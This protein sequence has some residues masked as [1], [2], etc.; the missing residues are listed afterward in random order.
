VLVAGGEQ[1]VVVR[2]YDDPADLEKPRGKQDWQLE[3]HIV[4]YPRTTGIWQTVWLEVVP[5]THLGSLR[6]RP[7]VPAWSI[8]VEACVGGA[9]RENLRL[10]VELRLGDEVLVD[11]AWAV[12]DGEV[13]R[14]IELIDPGIRSERRRLLWAPEHPTLLE[15][16]LRLV[17]PDGVLDTIHSYTALRSV[18]VMASA[19]CSTTGPSNCDSSST[20]ATGP[21]R[22]TPRGRRGD[23]AGR[24]ARP[25][26]R[27]QR[28]AQ[29]PEGRG[30]ALPAGGRRARL[31]V[32]GEMPSSYRFTNTSARGSRG[33]GSRCSSE[34]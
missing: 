3:P 24:R 18:R 34:T 27:L 33:S 6:W 4:W 31:L 30:P 29:A 12:R 15:A 2:A 1:E 10:E 26:A 11:D 25:G 28:R 14:R 19:S 17:G 20:R 8:G 22:A 13:R 9:R 7:D 21:R 5:E 16:D 32:W 23:R